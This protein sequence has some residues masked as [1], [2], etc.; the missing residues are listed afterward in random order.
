MSSFCQCF[1]C[2]LVVYIWQ[3]F[4]LD[5][6]VTTRPIE[7]TENRFLV[8]LTK[9]RTVFVLKKCYAGSFAP[10]DRYGSLILYI[11]G[12]FVFCD[13]NIYFKLVELW[14]FY[15]SNSFWVSRVPIGSPISFYD[16][17]KFVVPEIFMKRNCLNNLY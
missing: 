11:F 5:L 7:I 4:G 13:V 14:R 15:C 2:N 12:G 3:S 1:H 8:T 17:W 9:K 10:M 16:F 6:L